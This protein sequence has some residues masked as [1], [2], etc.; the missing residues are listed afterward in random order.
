MGPI[1]QAEKKNINAR[2]IEFRQ[3]WE[4]T[5]CTVMSDGWIDGKG[6]TLINFLVHC[7]GGTMFIKSVDASTHVKDA[8]LLC[9]LMDGFI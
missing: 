1:L 7:P 3:S 2:L 4:S 6:I 8:T 5:R 9:K